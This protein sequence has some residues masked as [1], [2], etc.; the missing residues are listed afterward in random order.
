MPLA[1]L[2]NELARFDINL[3]PLEVGNQFCE[4]KSELKFFEAALVE[5]CTIASPT[6]PQRRAIRDKATGRLADTARE[7]Y[8]AMLELIDDPAQRRRLA[9][10]AYSTCSPDSARRLAS[11]RCSRCWPVVAR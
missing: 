7:W 4:A 1:E 3:A 2:P 8:D 10:A 11:R 6:G 9:H 5:V